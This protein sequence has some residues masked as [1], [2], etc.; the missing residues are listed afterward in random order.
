MADRGAAK[1]H[2]RPDDA[3]SYT[4]NTLKYEASIISQLCDAARI[5]TVPSHNSSTKLQNRRIEVADRKMPARRDM[6]GIWTTWASG[7]PLS[8][9]YAPRWGQRA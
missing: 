2:A 4:A 1:N 6:G 9:S 8:P 7:T 5:V 3:R